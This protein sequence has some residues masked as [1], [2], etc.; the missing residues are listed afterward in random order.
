MALW[1]TNGTRVLQR[2]LE[3]IIRDLRELMAR[4]VKFETAAAVDNVALEQFKSHVEGFE[5]SSERTAARSQRFRREMRGYAVTFL[6]VACAALGFLLYH[7]LPYA[8][9][10]K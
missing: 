1:H 8:V 2:D 4:V 10:A 3:P 9:V 6:G 5:R 7:G